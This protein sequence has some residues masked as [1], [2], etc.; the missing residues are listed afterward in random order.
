MVGFSVFLSVR[1]SLPIVSSD[2]FTVHK[3]KVRI[4]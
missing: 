2:R 4:Y 1:R 3:W